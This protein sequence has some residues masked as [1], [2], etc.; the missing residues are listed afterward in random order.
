[1][2]VLQMHKSGAEGGNAEVQKC[3]SVEVQ[4]CK[5]GVERRNQ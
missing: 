1:M 4:K 3:K 2:K 5:T